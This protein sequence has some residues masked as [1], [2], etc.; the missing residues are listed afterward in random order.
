MTHAARVLVE[1]LDLLKQFSTNSCVIDLACGS[2][3]NGFE[4][5]KLNIPVTFADYDE[6]KLLAISA[7]LDQENLPGRTWLVDLENAE[8]DPLTEKSVD[9]CL[10]FNYLY[11]PRLKSIKDMITSG[12]LI[13][14]E[15]FTL[16]NRKFGRPNNPAYLLYPNELKEVFKGWEIL[17]YFEGEL[18]SPARAIANIIARK[19]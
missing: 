1:N 11:R 13:Y 12:G 16:E 15:T 10:V 19:P 14:Y 5:A 9:A 7:R 2:G 8:S 3:R 17:H 6:A 18:P 4:L